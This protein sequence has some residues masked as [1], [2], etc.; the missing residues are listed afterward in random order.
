ME[1]RSGINEARYQCQLIIKVII[2]GIIM[3]A[4]TKLFAKAAGLYPGGATGLSL[5]IQSMFH[6]FGNIKIP[7]SLINL[8]LNAVPVYIGFRYIGKR[9]TARSLLMILISSFVTDAVPLRP[10][11]HDIVL[12]SIF[13][14]II[15]GFAIGI[16]LRAESTSGGTDFIA[17]YFSEKKGV[18]TFNMVLVFNI[19]VLVTA[20]IFYGFDKALYS[21]IYQ[22]C[23]TQMIH[24]LYKTF[25]KQTLLIVT[26]KANEVCRAI[27]KESHHGATILQSEGSY[28]HEEKEMVYSV[29]SK[30]E[31][32]K[33]ADVIKKVDPEAFI[34]AIP[35]TDIR[36]KFFYRQY[37]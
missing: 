3:G 9:F 31:S 24:F 37:N 6:T 23:S 16:A 13:G 26:D 8:I 25:M 7:F 5:L 28:L 12:L 18:D 1:K 36:G 10:I 20:G 29:I 30:A 4:N 17:I 2:A 14:G 21:I 34:N 19:C 32:K 35:T 22:Y 15:N 11:T 33:V 27:Y